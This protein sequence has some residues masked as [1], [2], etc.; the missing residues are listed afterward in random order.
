MPDEY[1]SAV[2]DNV[3]SPGENK[4]VFL[5]RASAKTFTVGA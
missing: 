3:L 1:P 4:N 5:M 2:H